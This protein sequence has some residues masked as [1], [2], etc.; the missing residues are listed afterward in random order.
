M[1]RFGLPFVLAAVLAGCTTVAPPAPAP[2]VTPPEVTIVSNWPAAKA[3]ILPA[4][5]ALGYAVERDEEAWTVL[6]KPA[7]AGRPPTRLTVTYASIRTHTRVIADTQYLVAT[8]QGP[9]P[10]PAP[11]HPDRAALQAALDA[12]KREV[13]RLPLAERQRATPPPRAPRA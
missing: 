2:V 6:S 1:V 12:A 10:A 9:R 7:E 3:A 5:R 13:E 4:I 11:S 8:T